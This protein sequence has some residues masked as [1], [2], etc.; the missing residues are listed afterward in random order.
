L[1][2]QTQEI[3]MTNNPNQT[4]RMVGTADFVAADGNTLQAMNPGPGGASPINPAPHDAEPTDNGAGGAPGTHQGHA[5]RVPPAAER[6]MGSG[7]ASAKSQG[8]GNRA[9]QLYDAEHNLRKSQ[10]DGVL[11][12]RTSTWPAGGKV[13]V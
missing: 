2:D 5:D 8:K 6:Y 10:A 12:D 11:N 13:N 9:A 7:F 4:G 1:T 3:F